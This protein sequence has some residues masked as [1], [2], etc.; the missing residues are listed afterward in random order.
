[1]KIGQYCQ[2]QRCKHVELEQFWQAF[3]SRGFVS[4]SWA[5]LY[6]FLTFSVSPCNVFTLPISPSNFHHFMR[7]FSGQKQNITI[8]MPLQHSH[9]WAITAS[10]TTRPFCSRALHTSLGKPARLL[11]RVPIPSVFWAATNSCSA[12][13]R[14]VTGVVV[15]CANWWHFIG[16][17]LIARQLN[18]DSSS[19]DN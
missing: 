19:G 7:V 3:A 16:R 4:D 18:G 6:Q 10:N 5:F 2:R 8:V 17:H 14:L 1:M 12:S 11:L 9:S 15:V 13:G